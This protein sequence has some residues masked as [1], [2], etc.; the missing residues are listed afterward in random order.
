MEIRFGK[1]LFSAIELNSKVALKRVLQGQL[2]AWR[3]NPMLAQHM[4]TCYVILKRYVH[5]HSVVS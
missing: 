2:Y 4:L 1:L 3:R 5:G